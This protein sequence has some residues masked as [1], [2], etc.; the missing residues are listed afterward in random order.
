YRVKFDASNFAASQEEEKERADRLAVYVNAGILRVDKAQELAGLEVDPSQ[1]VYLRPANAVAVPV[2]DPGVQ[3]PISEPQPG[4]DDDDAG[5]G[6]PSLNGDGLMDR[7]R[8]RE[9][10]AQLEGD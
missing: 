2:G 6:E 7:N 9:I 5:V 10:I 4:S 1:A 3:Q 8:I